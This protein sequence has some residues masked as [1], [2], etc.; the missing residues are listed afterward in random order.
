M[1]SEWKTGAVAK[2]IARYESKKKRGEYVYHFE[3][4]SGLPDDRGSYEASDVTEFHYE[5]LRVPDVTAPWVAAQFVTDRLTD[6]VNAMAMR[7]K[8]DYSVWMKGLRDSGA[9]PSPAVRIAWLRSHSREGAKALKTSVIEAMDSYLNLGNRRA[10]VIAHI[11]YV[12][13]WRTMHRW[14]MIHGDSDASMRRSE[15][16]GPRRASKRTIGTLRSGAATKARKAPR[17]RR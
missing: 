9:D 7:D 12:P 13:N 2:Q 1:A 15:R 14:A 5:K 17:S 8:V 4:L 3:T 16:N 10:E 11:E 6:A